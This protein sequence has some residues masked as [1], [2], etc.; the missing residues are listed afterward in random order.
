MKKLNV[1]KVYLDDGCDTY[2]IIVPAESKKE[3]K[4]YVSGNGEIISVREHTEIG[5][6]I[7]KLINDLTRCGWGNEE[8]DL[9][10]RTLQETRLDY[11]SRKMM[12]KAL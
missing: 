8:I 5:I 12:G 9:I 1:Y 3:A 6:G 2:R 4:E 7:E 10:A 11:E